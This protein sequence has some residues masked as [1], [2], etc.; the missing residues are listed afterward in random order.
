MCGLA[1]FISSRPRAGVPDPG[2]AAAFQNALETMH[3]RGPDDTKVEFGDGLAFGFKRLAIIDREEAA[4]PVHYPC[5][6]PQAGRWT[7]V[8]NGEIYN[9]RELRADLVREHQATFATHGDSE[10]LAAA[11]HYWGA[12]ALPRLR[13]MFAFVAYDHWT[14]TTHAARDPFGIKPLYVLETSDGLF[15]ASE[16]KALLEFSG[17]SGAALDTDALAHYLTFQ[18]VPEP[19][20]LHRQVRR[21]APGHKLTWTP[22]GGMRQERYFRPSLRPLNVKPEA[23]YQAIQDALR[24]SVRKH[25][26][27]EVPVGTFL[28]SGVDSSAIVALAKEVKPDLHAFT[29]GFDDAAYSEIEIAQDTANQLGVR[30]TPTIITEDDVIRELPRI[31]QLLDDPVADPSLVPLYFL[32][33]TASQY[34]TVVLS[35]EGSD[36]LFGGYTIYREP[37][38]L[39]GIGKLPAGMKRGLRNLS[40]V[41]PE[42]MKGR[43]FLERGTTPIEERYWGN[44][45]IFSPEEKA[46]LMRFT[47]EPHTAITSHLYAETA[48]VDD[49]ASMQYVD[50][51]TWLPGDILAKADRM[52]MAHSLELRVPFLDQAVYAAAAG[53]PTELKLPHGGQG[54]KMA[55]REAMRGIVPESVRDRRKLGFPTPTRVWL[56]GQIGDW[57]GSLFDGSQAGHLLDLAYAQ[58]LLAEHRAGEAD[59]SRK[60]WTVA[61]FCL[62]HAITVEKS[63]VPHVPRTATM[64]RPAYPAAPVAA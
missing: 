59:N 16:R 13:G 38:S 44:A 56:K 35:G 43:S 27:A 3:H 48:D 61:M 15:M 34:V 18:Y 19:L 45:R 14:G 23:A 62:W 21:L 36:E 31:V 52:S 7:V 28:S 12:A 9:Y 60:V 46:N 64:L 42:G 63:I 4:Q 51:H 50:L 25:M 10:V 26:H 1:V 55:F 41:M 29:A 17:N 47:A 58:R 33:R 39:A 53:L 32:A 40:H 49:V 30:L 11:F 20:T 24:D 54:T 5:D 8:F 6:G 37:M 2:T 57:I 22:G